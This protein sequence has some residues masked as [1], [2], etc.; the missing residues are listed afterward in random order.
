PG[1]KPTD[2]SWAWLFCTPASSGV[3]IYLFK[4]DPSR[5]NGVPHAFLPKGWRG[6]IVTDG[7][8]AYSALMDR[9]PGD[10]T[11][12]SCLVH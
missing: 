4:Y 11:R 9:R 3:P 12:V 1:R 10:I 2:M 8:S 7:H 5:G 6:T